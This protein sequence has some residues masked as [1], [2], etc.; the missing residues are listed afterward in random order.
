[1]HLLESA[2]GLLLGDL[3]LGTRGSRLG[4]LGLSGSLGSLLGL[5]VEGQLLVSGLLSLGGLLGS[6]LLDQLEG[7]T[8]NSSLV[9]NGLSASLLRGLLRDT[10]LVLSSEKNGPGDSSGVLSLRK[11][12]GRLGGLESEDLGVRSDKQGTSTRVDLST[13]K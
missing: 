6:S 10:L 7:S 2:L 8:D 5:L 3:G 12:G 1:M 9:L 13:G 11:Q 4:L